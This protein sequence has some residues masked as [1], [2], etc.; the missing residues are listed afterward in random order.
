M[1]PKPG[2]KKT[3]ATF[4]W[5]PRLDVA[6]RDGAGVPDR[7]ARLIAVG[8]ARK[9]N[10]CSRTKLSSDPCHIGRAAVS[11]LEDALSA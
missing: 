4:F 7:A 9:R 2:E 6:F 1:V 3:Q 10:A 11:S 8:N 5:F